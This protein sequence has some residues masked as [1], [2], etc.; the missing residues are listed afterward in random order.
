MKNF[1]YLRPQVLIVTLLGFSSGLPLA[2]SGSTLSIWM[3]ERGI[4]LATIGYL[5][6]AGLPYTLKFLWAPL[7]DIFRIPLLSRWLGHR[8]GWL[9]ACLLATMVA[10]VFLGTRDPAVSPLQIGLGALLL[11][12]AS[13]TLDIVIDAYRIERLEAD[14]QAAGIAGYVAAYRIGMLVSGAGVILLTVWL[15]RQGIATAQAWPLAYA[16]AGLLTLSGAIAVLFAREPKLAEDSTRQPAPENALR[17]IKD[18]FSG[19]LAGFLQF[20]ALLILVFIVLFKLGD[21]LAGVMTAPYVLSLGYD[22][23]TY[24]GIVKGFGFFASLIGGFAG[25]WA[26]VRLTF[27]QSLWM[28]GACQAASNLIFIWLATVPVHPGALS[29]AIFVENFTG[30]IGNVIF[31][32]YLSA[33]ARHPGAT[34]TRYALLSALA[35]VGRTLISATAGVAAMT[36]GW[37]LFFIMTVVAALPGLLFLYILQARGHFGDLARANS[38]PAPQAG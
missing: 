32:A 24:A 10:I 31:V 7:V 23:A 34:A 21:A 29:A 5:S 37:T 35:S 3:V 13:A 38:E 28:A 15:E 8:R 26:A 14:E 33:L 4:D 25:G 20:D 16:A 22:K 27:A 12:A 1:V 19:A 30:G 2:L 11:A 18:N 9:I 6:L 36:F 17:R